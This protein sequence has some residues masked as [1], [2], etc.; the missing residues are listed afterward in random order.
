[1]SNENSKTELDLL[2]EINSKL[3]KLIGVL[4]IQSIEDQD[5]KIY[6]LKGLGFKET[7]IGLFV[8]T[9]GRIRDREGWKR[10]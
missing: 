7:E 4:V 9:K 10:K 6:A 5:D 3:D 1:M 8:V 2:N